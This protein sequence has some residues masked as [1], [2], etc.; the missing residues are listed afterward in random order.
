MCTRDKHSTQ[1]IYYYSLIMTVVVPSLLNIIF[2]SIIIFSVRSSTR[3]V[4]MVLPI[5]DNTYQQHTRDVYLLK[6]ILFIYVVFMI[7]W[8]P[9]YIVLAIDAKTRIQIWIYLLLQIPPVM[10]AAIQTFDLFIYN[11]EVRQYLREKIFQLLHCIF[12]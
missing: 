10:S 1:G 6:H 2:N 5:R 4:H 8:A 7:G 11:R 3:R 12:N 9:I